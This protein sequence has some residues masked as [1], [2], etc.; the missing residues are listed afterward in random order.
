MTGWS[1][2]VCTTAFCI[3]HVAICAAQQIPISAPTLEMREVCSVG[4]DDGPD[5]QLFGRIVDVAVGASGDMY[6]VDGMEQKVRAFDAFC[7]HLRDI[8]QRG[9]GPGEFV[10]I[11]SAQ[12]DG[13]TLYVLDVG[14]KKDHVF[15]LT[16]EYVKE[17]RDSAVWQ[18]ICCGYRVANLTFNRSPS[19]RTSYLRLQRRGAEDT[20]GIV[21]SGSAYAYPS[22]RPAS[23]R[24]VGPSFGLSVSLTML[25]DSLMVV[26]D[27]YEGALRFH[28]LAEDAPPRLVRAIALPYRAP[29]LSTADHRAV[30]RE[31]HRMF[32]GRVEIREPDRWSLAARLLYDG[33]GRLWV[34]SGDA[35]LWFVVSVADG[36]THAY[37]LPSGIR[38]LKVR[39]NELVAATETENRSPV[40]VRYAFT[41]PDESSR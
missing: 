38:V 34:G 2:A 35:S 20:L 14:G 5:Y 6:I 41:I 22:G 4:A 26:A 16:G 8:G 32:G 13:D 9:P 31:A 24:M 3:W 18:G 17:L 28:A 25:A 29:E 23:G 27:G 36:Q 10:S 15:L 19:A 12:I 40:V 30:A 21:H 7:R 39:E 33:G 11:V 37:R 1:Y